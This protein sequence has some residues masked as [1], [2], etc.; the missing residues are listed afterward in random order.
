MRL[1][2]SNICLIL[3]P[4]F[5][6]LITICIILEYQEHVVLALVIIPLIVCVL[7]VSICG[8]AILFYLMILCEI[9]ENK[10]FTSFEIEAIK[11]KG[12]PTLY[13]IKKIW[14]S[15]IFYFNTKQNRF[16]IRRHIHSSYD[17]LEEA[18]KEIEHIYKQYTETEYNKVVFK[19]GKK[20]I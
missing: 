5:A 8:I 11:R 1:P 19:K 10:Y 3:V 14:L 4:L 9:S 17:S 6:V 2:F 18:L 16:S 12:K 13:F 15:E 20:L 7:S